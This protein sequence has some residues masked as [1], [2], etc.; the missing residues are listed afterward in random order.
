[1]SLGLAKFRHKAV[2]RAVLSLSTRPALYY[3][4][5]RVTGRMDDLCICR[6]TELVIE[7]YPRSANSTT[8]HGFLE[9]QA[10]PVRVAHH[11]HHAAQL[12]RAARWG[13]PAIALVREPRAAIMS[14]L[15]LAEEGR[16]RTGRTGRGASLG[17]CHAAMG[18]SA[19]YRAILPHADH[20]LI[21]PFERATVDIEAVIDALNRRFGTDFRSA[22]EVVSPRRALGWHAMPNPLRQ[23]IKAALAEAFT[24]ELHR[25]ARLRWL[26][27]DCDALHGR[28]RAFA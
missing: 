8:V 16:R 14:N 15:A 6:D 5:R 26:L 12:I 18:W 19:F 4:A 28:V 20:L 7:G 2:H 17:F 21:V 10:R 3:A 13:I 9:R 22:P 24:D 11:K 25:S 1:M 27:E 23:E